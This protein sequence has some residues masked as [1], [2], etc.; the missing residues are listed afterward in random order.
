MGTNL[1]SPA[2]D[3][4]AVER[5]ITLH[6]ERL[7]LAPLPVRWVLDAEDGL[8]AVF[9][10]AESAAESAAWSAALS[11]ARSAA[12]SAAESAAPFVDAY[13]AGLWLFWVCEREVIA[14][15]RPALQIVDERLHCA[16]GPA[17]AWPNGA[18]YWFWRGVQ[19][20]ERVVAAPEGL[21]SGEILNERNA[22]VRRVMLERFGPER[23]LLGLG[24]QPV[25][26]DRFGA[27][28]R[29]A[30]ED[31]EPLVLVRVTNSTPEPDGSRKKYLLRVHP[32]LRPLLPDGG[33]GTAQ[34]LTARNA[35]AST[36]G[37]RGEDYA[38]VVET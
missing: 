11:A 1:G 29:V 35:V 22:E 5:A 15:P 26:E 8:K 7:G 32:E 37:L 38:P 17:V 3:R 27:L 18:R 14:V 25:H 12:E 20:P 19:V 36:F 6:L 9:R 33:L 10:E 24:A 4:P 30:L 28:Y 21:T 16:D 13:E 34:A 2:V 23:F 31:D